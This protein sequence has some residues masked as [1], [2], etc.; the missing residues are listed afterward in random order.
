[1]HQLKAEGALF[2][3][4]MPCMDGANGR[5]DMQKRGM[6]WAALLALC[7]CGTALAARA[8]RLCRGWADGRCPV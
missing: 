2:L 8:R 1:M 4:A 5:T 3:Y 7:G 6:T